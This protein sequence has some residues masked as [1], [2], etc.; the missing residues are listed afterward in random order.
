MYKIIPKYLGGPVKLIGTVSVCT[1]LLG[2]AVP[3]TGGLQQNPSCF[4]VNASRHGAAA[5]SKGACRALGNHSVCKE[6]G[7]LWEKTGKSEHSEGL[8]KA[9]LDCLV[10]HWHL[11]N[12]GLRVFVIFF[13]EKVAL[14]PLG[15]LYLG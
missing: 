6:E 3:R 1:A 8:G 2:I 10:V 13:L 11:R 9:L 5:S 14:N 4:G 15:S 12:L 7:L